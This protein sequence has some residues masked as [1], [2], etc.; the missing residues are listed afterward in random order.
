ME[1]LFIEFGRGTA[2]GLIGMTHMLAT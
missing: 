1:V 2:Y